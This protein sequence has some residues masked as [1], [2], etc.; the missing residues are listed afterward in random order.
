MANTLLHPTRV[1]DKLVADDV[2]Q[3]VSALRYFGLDL[4]LEQPL[5]VELVIE[6]L[7]DGSEV[8]ELRIR[9]AERVA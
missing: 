7:S 1:A 4:P 5:A 6:T 3:L 9:P 2:E 8:S